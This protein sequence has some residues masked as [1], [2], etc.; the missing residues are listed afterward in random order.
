VALFCSALLLALGLFGASRLV[1][2]SP[3]APVQSAV[4]KDGMK[5]IRDIPYVPG[6]HARQRLDLYLPAK[7]TGVRPLL[8]WVHGGGWQGGSKEG[9]DAKRALAAGYALASVEYRL[10]QHAVYPAQIEDCKA[11]VRWLRAHATEYELDPA[12]VGAWGASAGGHLVALLGTTGQTREFD[13]GE[14][15]DQSSAVQCVVNWFG[16]SDFLH[17]GERSAGFEEAETA[18]SRLL[19]GLVKNKRDLARRA[20]PVSFVSKESAPFLILHGDQDSLV[21]LQQSTVLHEAL[22]KAGVPSQLVVLPGAKHGGAA[23]TRPERVQEMGE[24]LARYLKPS[25]AA[26]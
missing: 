2:Q 18:V 14:N 25:P 13:T 7:S 15:L 12:R 4:E 10:S 23:F 5:I 17:W 16:P 21:P 26:D 22:Q 19:G 11:A 6:G 1:G 8:V 9:V 24:F 20:S 3:D